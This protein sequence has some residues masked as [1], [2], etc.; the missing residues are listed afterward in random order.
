MIDR[1]LS[2]FNRLDLLG[3]PTPLEKLHRLSTW[4][5]HD[6]YVKR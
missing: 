3:A 4:V 1:Q 6:I 2:R 5:G